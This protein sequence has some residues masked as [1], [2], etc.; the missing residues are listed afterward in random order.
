MVLQKCSKHNIDN[1]SLSSLES[2][3]MGAVLKCP[4][5]HLILSTA[6]PKSTKVNSGVKHLSSAGTPSILLAVASRCKIPAP[7]T[8]KRVEL[9]CWSNFFT[10]LDALM[11]LTLLKIKNYCASLKPEHF[12][13]THEPSSVFIRTY[14]LYSIARVLKTQRS[15]F[16]KRN[17]P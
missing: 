17:N 15:I 1:N 5:S 9:I 16:L 11:N 6:R 13:R 10:I 2:P 3:P 7:W 4:P 14:Y 12:S 8:W